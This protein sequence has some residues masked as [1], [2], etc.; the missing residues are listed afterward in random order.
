[1]CLLILAPPHIGQ[2][3]NNAIKLLIELFLLVV[4]VIQHKITI[5]IIKTCSPVLI[6]GFFMCFSTL[7]EYGISSKELN[8]L[9]T[10]TAFFLFF[11]FVFIFSEK[12][13]LD[14]TIRVI[15][16]NL[17]FYMI[18]IDFF[19]ILTWGKGIGGT[20]IDGT[21]IEEPI[22]LLANKFTAAYLHMFAI[23]TV[24][25]NCKT[26]SRRQIMYRVVLVALYSLLI[27]YVS[28]TTTGILGCLIVSVLR[29]LFLYNRRF[30]ELLSNP[31]TVLI[32]FVLINILLLCSDL[33]LKNP[34]I[35]KFLL[36]RSHTSTILSGRVKM[37]EISMKAIVKKPILGY[38]INCDIVKTTLSFGNAQNGMLKLL[39]DFGIVGAVSFCFVL[40]SSFSNMEKHK[41]FFYQTGIIAFI[42]GMLICSLVE[43]NLS[44]LF[45]L[46]CSVLKVGFSKRSSKPVRLLNELSLYK[47]ISK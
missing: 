23:S 43:I 19:V 37:Y 34:V 5:R 20:G 38:G 6:Y 33:I 35:V 29:I 18:I 45:I 41:P 8:A 39:L 22:Y 4:L 17:L 12:Y 24:C 36:A 2:R 40:F 11:V 21:K 13:S 1:M 44:G 42:Y 26:K 16:N 14:H 27:C 47:G 10:A 32:F 30:F 7:I 3:N 25:Q 28:D 15:T 31:Y 9:V 46:A